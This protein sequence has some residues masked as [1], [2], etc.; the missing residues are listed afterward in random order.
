[1]FWLVVGGR[2]NREIAESLRVTV[3][4]VKTHRA[5]VFQKMDVKSVL[6]LVKKADILR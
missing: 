6:E 2:T 4:T 1:V 5:A 3:N